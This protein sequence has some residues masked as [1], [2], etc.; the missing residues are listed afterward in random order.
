MADMNIQRDA[1]VEAADGEIGR[2]KHVV[3]DHQTKEVTDLVVGSGEHGEMMIPMS[4]VANVQGDR[5]TLRGNRS[6]FA[7]GS[8]FDMSHYHPVDSETVRSETQRTAQR[9]GAPLQDASKN[10]VEIGGRGA[11]GRE[12]V[13]REMSSSE[14]PYRLSLREEHLTARKER[15]QAGEVQLG[16]RVVEHTE[17][18][19]VPVTEERVVIERQA[20]SGAPVQG[21]IGDKANETINVPVTRE[22]VTAEKETVASEEVNVRKEAVQRTEQVQGTVRKEELVVE[23]DKGGNAQVVDESRRTGTERGTGDTRPG[24][25]RRI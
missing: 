19:Q 16:K 14:Q 18:M 3:V 23:G 8:R 1:R 21:T 20:A 25:D 4:A 6:Q 24:T 2:V 9:G 13:G 7:S 12:T 10:E 5:V 11:T 15:E 17:S 22:R